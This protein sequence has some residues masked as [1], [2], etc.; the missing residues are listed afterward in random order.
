MRLMGLEAVCPGPHTSKKGK[1]TEHQV[2]PYLLRG[3]PIER[4]GQVVGT[5]ITYLPLFRGFL[6]MVA[7]AD[8]YSRAI[9]SWELSNSLD[10]RFCLDALGRIWDQ[11]EID[12]VNTDQGAQYTS[13]AFVS[14][15]TG[16]EGVRLSMDGKGRASDNVFTERFWRTIKYEEVYLREYEDGRHAWESLNRYIHYYNHERPHS[17]LGGATPWEVF[18]G[19]AKPPAI[20]IGKMNTDD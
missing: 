18:Q 12:I 1:G 10:A 9:L 3:L 14:A 6:Y 20:S 2:F 17:R 5:D 19:K 8:W 7:F 13:K 4:P 15:V 11:A 16:R